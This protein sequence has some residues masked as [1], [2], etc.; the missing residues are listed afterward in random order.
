MDSRDNEK[1][2]V[3]VNGKKVW[4]KVAN[5]FNNCSGWSGKGPADFPQ[6]WGGKQAQHVCYAD[7]TV[8]VD[9]KDK[10]KLEF[11]SDINQ[12]LADE[13]WAF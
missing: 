6:P 5:G 4:E 1:D 12:A 9:C 13:G 11:R 3:Y 10:L 8:D 2:H 7:V